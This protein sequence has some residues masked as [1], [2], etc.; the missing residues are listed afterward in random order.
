MCIQ[1]AVLLTEVVA[2]PLT[3]NIWLGGQPRDGARLRSTAK[4]FHALA[5]GVK[6]L[7]AYYSKL[8]D[9]IN[10]SPHPP[11]ESPD[12]MFPRITAFDPKP[13]GRAT[14][15][16][17]YLRKLAED[18]PTNAIFRA[19]TL[20][21]DKKAVVVEFVETYDPVA[22]ELLAE[23]DLAPRLLSCSAE[24]TA[25]GLF[26]VV[27]AFIQ[28]HDLETA[29]PDSAV[30]PEEVRTKARGA[31]SI[32]HAKGIVFGDLRK[33]NIMLQHSDSGL[34]LVDFDWCAADGKGRYPV[35]LNEDLG[36]HRNV[37]R[38]G[39]MRLEHDM[40]MLEKL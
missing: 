28:G 17:R 38:N 21:N 36:W 3:D 31:L 2:Q 15:R 22:H 19:E 1:G 39:V 7:S 10:S 16:F 32:L 29:F 13:L 12:P 5:K 25:G 34:K 18:H 4:V 23:H 14:V 37:Q 24:S 27:M 26:M 35:T 20:D 9:E 30:V 6:S 40:F 11:P 8:D 33:P